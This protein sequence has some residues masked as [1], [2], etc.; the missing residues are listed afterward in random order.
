[1]FI[2]IYKYIFRDVKSTR[3]QKPFRIR[4]SPSQTKFRE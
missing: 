2:L 1:M 3:H 4:N